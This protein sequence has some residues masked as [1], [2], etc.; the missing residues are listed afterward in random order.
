MPFVP[1]QWWIVLPIKAPTHGK[2]RLQPP[3][4]VPHR[5]LAEA[6]ARD[7]VSAAADTVGAERL[8][9]VTDEVALCPP[10]AVQ[11]DDPGDG[12]NGAVRSGLRAVSAL[13]P[14]PVAVLLADHPALTAGDLQDALHACA[15]HGRAVIPD[16]D[17]TGTALLTAHE[18]DTLQPCFGPGSAAAH[19]RSAHVVF[20]AADGLRVDVDDRA[21]L[22]RAQRIGLGRHTRALLH[23]YGH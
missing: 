16:A 5:Q 22:Q 7:T 1:D 15:G 12:L 18:P 8:V 17:G 2:S 20:D 4:G 6:I 9:V 13:G 10:G 11:V 19:A 3:T 23:R 14:G 21:S